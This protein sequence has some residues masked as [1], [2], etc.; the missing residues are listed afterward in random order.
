MIPP[1]AEEAAEGE[2][3]IILSQSIIKRAFWQIVFSHT[4]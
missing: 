4:V 2:H 3:F 1:T